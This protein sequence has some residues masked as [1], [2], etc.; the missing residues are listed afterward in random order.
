MVSLALRALPFIA[1]LLACGPAWGAGDGASFDGVPQ[2]VEGGWLEGAFF[3]LFGGALLVSALGVCVSRSVV[4]M[5]T[6]LFGALASVAVLYLLL[7]APFLG[8]IQLI[9]YAGGT[10]ILLVFGVMLTS[11]SPFVRFE[12]KPIEMWAAGGVAILLFAGLATVLTRTHWPAEATSYAGAS[13]GVIG[14]ELLTTYLVPFEVASVVLLVVMI[15][16]AYL[17]RQENE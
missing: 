5:A 11:K 4:R 2:V 16:A 13:V 6:W 12:C 3:Y 9:V 10:L 1:V 15:A 14:K 8:A 7:G 17:A